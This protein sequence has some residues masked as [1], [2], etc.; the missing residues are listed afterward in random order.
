LINSYLAV[1]DAFTKDT[2]D[3]EAI[4]HF[5]ETAKAL[6]EQGDPDF[7]SHILAISELD[8]K[9]PGN[10][11]ESQ[12][13]QFKAVSEKMIAFLKLYL[14]AKTEL[15]IAYC[16]MAK[17]SW[18]TKTKTV[19]NPYYGSQMLT[20]GEITGRITPNPNRTAE[21]FV[22]GYFCPIYPDRI[23]DKAEQCPIDKF[24]F[25]LVRMEKVLAV[26]ESAVID[27]G[28]RKVVYRESAPGTF[29]M[30]EIKTG[31][32]A[33]EFFPVITGLKSGDRVATRGAFLVDAENRLNP[34]ASAQYFGAT[35]GPKTEHKH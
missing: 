32:R 27:T 2:S 24:P 19:V 25:K 17:A 22:T 31:P 33:G 13:N 35:G 5:I 4:K 23:F 16:P 30:V 7:H 34:A 12:R 20:C 18:L 10:N 8:Q 26:P 15:Y 3:V 9:L 1:S 11:L 6:Q 28:V 29:D 14:P 21:N